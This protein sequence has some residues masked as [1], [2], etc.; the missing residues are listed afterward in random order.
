[1]I[2]RM[3]GHGD[4]PSAASIAD[5]VNERLSARRQ[6]NLDTDF[7]DLADDSQTDNSEIPA[8]LRRQ[9]N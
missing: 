7:D 2:E 5:R 8:F 4:K 3:A 1:M 6:G 9:A